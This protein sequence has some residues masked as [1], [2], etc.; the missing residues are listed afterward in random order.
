MLAVAGHGD[1]F[2]EAMSS[3]GVDIHGGVLGEGPGMAA[4]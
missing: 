1:Q 2:V 3:L 4:Y